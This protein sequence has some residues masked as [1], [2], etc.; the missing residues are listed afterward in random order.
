MNIR[1]IFLSLLF[2][3]NPLF[4]VNNDGKEAIQD[5]QTTVEAQ[6]KISAEATFKVRLGHLS[7]F[8]SLL[9]L[10]VTTFD[11]T[12]S[13]PFWWLATLSICL[14]GGLYIF[15][16]TLIAY[17]E[18]DD[19]FIGSLNCLFFSGTFALIASL[20]WSY[21]VDHNSHKRVFC[22]IVLYFLFKALV[23]GL[24]PKAQEGLGMP[25]TLKMASMWPDA[26]S[27]F[28]FGLLWFV[29]V[30]AKGISPYLIFGFFWIDML[31]IYSYHQMEIDEVAKLIPDRVVRGLEKIVSLD[32]AEE[33][34]DVYLS[35]IPYL[36]CLAPTLLWALSDR[37]SSLE[38]L[39]FAL[40]ISGLFVCIL[41]TLKVKEVHIG[42][43]KLPAT[44]VDIDHMRIVKDAFVGAL[45]TVGYYQYQLYCC[46][47][48]ADEL[49]IKA[50]AFSRGAIF[51]VVSILIGWLL[52]Q[53]VPTLLAE[54]SLPQEYD[55]ILSDIIRVFVL[56]VGSYGLFMPCATWNFK[57]VGISL[58]CFA[59]VSY[60]HRILPYLWDIT[61]VRFLHWV[62]L[63]P[64]WF[65]I[66]FTM[67]I[68]FVFS[69]PIGGNPKPMNDEAMGIMAALCLSVLLSWIIRWI[70]WRLQQFEWAG[71]FLHLFMTFTYYM[72]PYLTIY[73]GD[74]SS[75]DFMKDV[76]G[77]KMIACYII[78]ILLAKQLRWC[79]EPF[80]P[81][82][83]RGQILDG[84]RIYQEPV[85]ALDLFAFG[86]KVFYA[87]VL[88]ALNGEKLDES[89]HLFFLNLVYI[90]IFSF[91]VDYLMASL[92]E[93]LPAE[94]KVERELIIQQYQR[95]TNS[96][97]A[98]FGALCMTGGSAWLFLVAI[99]G[100]LVKG[101]IDLGWFADAMEKGYI[102]LDWVFPAW[103]WTGIDYLMA[104]EEAEDL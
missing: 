14:A 90:F 63:S 37:D 41:R 68:P 99:L 101:M 69:I 48:D 23:I 31:G 27:L 6:G 30:H 65:A 2:L 42:T 82:Q 100:V 53:H 85:F 55:F 32:Y 78:L 45:F 10:A 24:W 49:Q 86:E 34:Y 61:F 18:R 97:F 13:D 16:H 28:N 5:D 40:F 62:D 84:W 21:L 87:F 94:V 103:R 66:D 56:G 89:G 8:T 39:G 92:L 96:A 52:D 12:G 4:A 79:E 50:A 1:Y 80:V 25:L 74:V 54:D 29:T 88:F 67:I 60:L 3:S 81:F 72:L 102:S 19:S 51:I 70:D 76:E 20:G 73:S 9:C 7:L 98:I 36:F 17:T 43:A 46:D 11:K 15:T 44:Q 77:Q 64:A 83:A 91:V 93:W 35:G 104:V 38:Q 26:V 71:K 75:S 59:L 22:C 33:E 47:E 58:L 95:Y 57:G